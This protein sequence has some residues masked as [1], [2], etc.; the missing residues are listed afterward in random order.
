MVMAHSRL[1]SFLFV[2]ASF[3]AADPA[4]GQAANAEELFPPA[5]RQIG[6]AYADS[7]RLVKGI[8]G[9]AAAVMVKGSMWSAGLG[10]ADRVR[11]MAVTPTT[12]FQIGGLTT[13]LTAVTTLKL[14]E[15]GRVYLDSPVQRYLPDYPMVRDSAAI[16]PRLLAGHLAG[17]RHFGRNEQ[18]NQKHYKDLKAG[19]VTFQ[20]DPL[21]FMP[22][23]RYA[24]SACGYNLL[25]ATLEAADGREFATIVRKTVTNPL[26]MKRTEADGAEDKPENRVQPYARDVEGKVG[27]AP[28]VDMS[29]RLPS[30]GYWST[31]ED[32][33]RF[34]TGILRPDYLRPELQKQLFSSLKNTDEQETGAGL[35]WNLGTDAAG[36]SYAWQEGDAPGGHAFLLVYPE[37][38]IAIA[39]VSNLSRVDV[40]KKEAMRLRRLFVGK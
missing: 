23:E 4:A 30:M 15:A 9:M 27:N 16:T 6:R 18:I 12:Q 19:L 36:R 32:L 28:L 39:L 29:D 35:G 10:Y 25:G 37:E 17:I 26:K 22:G 11:S 21:R 8:P 14:V 20:N 2:V 38:Q 5:A 13:L 33:V 1:S 31:A 3:L 24:Y 40:G 34:G 7:V